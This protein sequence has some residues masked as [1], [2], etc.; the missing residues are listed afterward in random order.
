MC[1]LVL[2]GFQMHRHL[3]YSMEL[4]RKMRKELLVSSR[5]PQFQLSSLLWRRFLRMSEDLWRRHHDER[6]TDELNLEEVKLKYFKVNVRN[7]SLHNPLGTHPLKCESWISVTPSALPSTG[8]YKRTTPPPSVSLL[9]A[10]PPIG[11]EVI[12]IPRDMNSWG[13][14]V[15]NTLLPSPWTSFFVVTFC[16]PNFNW[17]TCSSLDSTVLTSL[18]VRPKQ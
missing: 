8:W 12:K 10:D 11:D 14:S 6:L 1:R 5:L 4:Q 3:L 7:F 15:S 2:V 9:T 17:T 16:S 18:T 13:I